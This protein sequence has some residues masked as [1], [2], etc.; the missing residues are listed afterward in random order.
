MK[1]WPPPK[2]AST[3][4]VVPV[5]A[6]AGIWYIL[7]FMHN[8]PNAN[9]GEMLQTWFVEVPERGIFWWLAILP[10]LCLALSI[11]YLSPISTRK[12]G[13]IALA[14]IGTSV[15]VAAW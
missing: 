12:V 3:T 13:A 10:A 4:Y 6:V 14:L 2:M 8:G 5:A 11:A 15:A 9:Y 7:L 1:K